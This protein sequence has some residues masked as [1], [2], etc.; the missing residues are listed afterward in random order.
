MNQL[1]LLERFKLPEVLAS[2]LP[3]LDTLL[4]RRD[5][6]LAN[7]FTYDG[8]IQEMDE[9]LANLDPEFIRSGF[10]ISGRCWIH[11]QARI[12]ENVIIEG[13][14]IVCKGA[15]VGP[16]VFLGAGTVVG[17]Y[18]KVGL[19]VAATA[20]IIGA[21]SRIKYET[22]IS[23]TVIGESAD[24]SETVAVAS[25]RQHPSPISSWTSSGQPLQTQIPKLGAHI[26]AEVKIA[27]KS[28]IM[29]GAVIQDT[30]K[31]QNS[32]VNG[33]LSSLEFSNKLPQRSSVWTS[34]TFALGTLLLLATLLGGL[35]IREALLLSPSSTSSQKTG[36][37]RQNESTALATEIEFPTTSAAAL[38]LASAT[39][40]RSQ[41]SEVPALQPYGGEPFIPLIQ[42]ANFTVQVAAF[43]EYQDAESLSNLLQDY[44]YPSYVI[45]TKIPD[46]QHYYRVRVGQFSTADEALDRGLFLSAQFSDVIP[47]P[48]IVPFE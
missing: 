29:P 44:G 35:L 25:A 36:A 26:G 14:C 3:L 40:S 38:P 1:T 48:W 39:E 8:L 37:P 21:N 32:V 23:N 31:I 17:P 41:P 7:G 47:A 22:S 6:A 13:P 4:Y 16:R 43:K 5:E 33:Y 45:E 2:R 34:R 27:A 20:T 19:G 18:A 46:A 28:L 30:V 11:P 10:G 42:E 15:E 12:K 9:A 24:I